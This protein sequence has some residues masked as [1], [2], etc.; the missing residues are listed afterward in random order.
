V[1]DILSMYSC[2]TLELENNKIA[3]LPREI[4]RLTSLTH[5]NVKHNKLVTLPF[6][7]CLV[8]QLARLEVAENPL[9]SP[10]PRNVRRGISHILNYLSRFLSAEATKVLDFSS[11]GL[12]ALPPDCA[13]INFHTLILSR[14]CIPELSAVISKLPNLTRLDV[15]SNP[16]SVFPSVLKK[17]SRL[18]CVVLDDISLQELPS[19]LPQVRVS[20][21]SFCGN[22]LS[23]LPKELPSMATL[24]TLRLSRNSIEEIPPVLLECVQLEHLFLDANRIQTLP[25]N[26]HALRKLQTIDVSHN[27]LEALPATLYSMM[28]L[29]SLSIAH[30]KFR[31]IPP[32]IGDMQNLE[33]INIVSNSVRQ[34]PY[35]MGRLMNLKTIQ[36]IDNPLAHPLELFALGAQA[37][38]AYLSSI[39][40]SQKSRVLR[41]EAAALGSFPEDA[42]SIQ[43]LVDLNLSD[44][45]IRAIPASIALCSAH[46]LSVL[47]LS[48]N[49]LQYLPPEI[50]LLTALTRWIFHTI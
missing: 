40:E 24:T 34:L 1:F 35:S 48:R 16:I 46:T 33:H 8:K 45:V 47:R 43:G 21:L 12:D 28:S 4:S 37:T 31:V 39:L 11:L 14:N 29:T 42:L 38:V 50:S 30:N 5:L 15:S 22:A 27:S 23:V 13:S 20:E 19:W 6:T 36:F 2:R 7:L 3:E 18:K 44:N 49:K 32:A 25:D 41:L 10:D 9:E 26:I 17:A